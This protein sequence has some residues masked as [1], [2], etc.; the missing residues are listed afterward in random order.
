M[1]LKFFVMYCAIFY[2]VNALAVE[3]RC[4]I[5]FLKQRNL[6]NET[7]FPNYFARSRSSNCDQIVKKVVKNL[8]EKHIDYVGENASVDNKTYQECL[9]S[10]FDRHRMDEK[11]LKIK[12]FENEPQQ[13][14]QLEQIRDDFLQKIKSVCAETFLEV[15]S[16]RFKDFV[17]DEGGPSPKVMNHPALLK[18][19]ENIV[20]MNLYAVEKKIL[21]PAVYNLKLKLINQTNEDCKYV[22]FDVMTLIMD[23]WHIRRFSEDDNIQRCYIGILLETQAVDLFIKNCLL[24]QLQLSQEQKK[25]EQTSFLKKSVNVHEMSFNCMLNNFERI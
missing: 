6:L 21:D 10:E 25:N 1:M 2:A 24:S 7:T 20:C 23:E 3:D 14:T 12:A 16:Q 19:K 5:E 15:S 22:L 8:Y 17:S 9:K 4:I 11:F 18:I 13:L